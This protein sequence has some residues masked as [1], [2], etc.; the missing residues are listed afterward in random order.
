M[1]FLFRQKKEYAK[2]GDMGNIPRER[3][4]TIEFDC[5]FR[6]NLGS[7]HFSSIMKAFLMLLPHLLQDFFFRRYLSHSP[8]MRWAAKRSL[9][10]AN[11]VAMTRI[12][13]GRHGMGEGLRF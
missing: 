7:S 4:I 13:C 8:S 12:L 11:V 9:L 1:V 2:E 6:V 5:Q 10:L 3:D